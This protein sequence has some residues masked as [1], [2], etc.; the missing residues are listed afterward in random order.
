MK[1][2]VPGMK[3]RLSVR[4]PTRRTAFSYATSDRFAAR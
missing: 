2:S 1:G 3:G 4:E